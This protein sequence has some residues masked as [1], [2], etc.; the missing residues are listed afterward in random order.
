MKENPDFIYICCLFRK[1]FK[2]IF[3]RQEVISHMLSFLRFSVWCNI[4][5][6]VLNGMI[7]HKDVNVTASKWVPGS[8]EV[9]LVSWAGDLRTGDVQQAEGPQGDVWSE[10]NEEQD[11]QLRAEVR[12]ERRQ[13]TELTVHWLQCPHLHLLPDELRWLPPGLARLSVPGRELWVL[14]CLVS[15]LTALLQT[16]TARRSSGA[17]LTSSTTRRGRGACSTSYR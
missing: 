9:S 3:N 13:E 6:L 5:L 11:H 16:T 12:W 4:D 8:S 2:A 1:Y 15:P 17:T 14:S 10:D 7:L